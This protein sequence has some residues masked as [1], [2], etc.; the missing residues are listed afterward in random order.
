MSLYRQLNGKK[1]I[2]TWQL[3]PKLR[4][5]VQ[6]GCRLLFKLQG[7]VLHVGHTHGI[8]PPPTMGLLGSGTI[9]SLALFSNSSSS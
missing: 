1:R 9:S 4:P 6:S 5:L 2:A 3:A 8:P 7:L